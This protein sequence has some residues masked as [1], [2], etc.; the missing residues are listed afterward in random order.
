MILLVLREKVDPRDRR[1][2]QGE[3]PWSGVYQVPEPDT[4]ICG[5]I[6]GAQFLHQE[7]GTQTVYFE[8]CIES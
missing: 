4:A 5:H 8:G 1:V 7:N 3:C 2:E 6:C